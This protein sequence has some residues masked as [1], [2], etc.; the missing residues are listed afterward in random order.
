[1][2]LFGRTEGAG[3]LQIMVY[4]YKQCPII[5]PIP[6][7]SK[8]FNHFS[9]FKSRTAY[10]LVNMKETAPLEFDQEDRKELDDLVL[11]ELGFSDPE[12]RLRIR[13]EIYEWL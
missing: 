2:E 1:M 10:R 13:S 9:T 4:E 7:L 3:A 6:G 5:Q 12:E 8:K 11:Q